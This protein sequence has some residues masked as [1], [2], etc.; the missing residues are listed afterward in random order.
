LQVKEMTNAVL[1][2]I[3]VLSDG[4]K[5]K[6]CRKL[7]RIPP[8]HADETVQI[9]GTECA[10]TRGINEVNYLL[11]FDETGFPCATSASLTFTQFIT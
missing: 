7:F 1:N 2:A 8:R 9:F 5:R 3:I 11:P 6:L 4:S 10:Q